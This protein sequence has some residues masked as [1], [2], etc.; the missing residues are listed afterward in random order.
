MQEDLKRAQRLIKIL[1]LIDGANIGRLDLAN[2]FDVSERQIYRDIDSLKEAHF[3]IIYS[4][5]TGT[6]TF[7][8]GF[9]LKKISL[10]PTELQVLLI[11]KQMLYSIGEEFA[12]HIDNF[13]SRLVHECKTPSSGSKPLISVR[14]DTPVN[15][16]EIESPYKTLLEAIDYREQV[17][18]D[19]LGKNGKYVKRQI[20]PYRLFH[21]DGFWYVI[22]Y[23]HLREDLRTF[24]LDKIRSVTILHRY[25]AIRDNFDFDAYM[26]N[27]WKKFYLGDPEE[28]TIR[29]SPEAAKDIKRK[30]WHLS[31]EIKDNQDGSID[32][33]ATISG[34]DEIMKWILSWGSKAKVLSP[35][36][37]KEK[38]RREATLITK[39]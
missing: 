9:S 25:F 8:N 33:T 38:I 2:K 15:F 16:S 28:V 23:C 10:Q 26:A 20:D 22:G 6:Y 13:F 19:H 31:Q 36:A 11:A 18:I 32:F 21:S 12:T 3:P 27:C 7:L 35:K 14:M 1:Q 4:K 34:H 5:K 37:L 17:E 29:F 30:K 24:A 39:Q